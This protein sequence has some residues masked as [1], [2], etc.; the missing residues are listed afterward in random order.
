[1]DGQQEDGTIVTTMFTLLDLY[2]AGGN[3]CGKISQPLAAP[4]AGSG[5]GGKACITAG[6]RVILRI[7][8][9]LGTWYF[10]M[11]RSFRIWTDKGHVFCYLNV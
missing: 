3:A 1:M 2:A 5:E 10:L 11:L 8:R 6:M 7:G 4:E 9:P